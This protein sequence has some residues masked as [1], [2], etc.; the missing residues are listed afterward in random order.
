MSKRHDIQDDMPGWMK[1]LD[2]RYHWMCKTV[3][4]RYYNPE[5]AQLLGI[6]VIFV[7]FSLVSVYYGIDGSEQLAAASLFLVAFV[8]VTAYRVEKR[9]RAE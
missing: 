6:G 7:L 1:R 4:G 9:W 8:L 5:I 2:D 3:L